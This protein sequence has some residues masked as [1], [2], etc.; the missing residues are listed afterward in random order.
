MFVDK[1]ERKLVLY[2]A[3]LIPETQE[4]DRHLLVLLGKERPRIAYI[5]SA[6]DPTR[7]Y[8]QVQQAYYARYGIDLAPYF[9]LDKT[10]R[11][12]DLS[13][14]LTADAIHLSGGQTFYFLHWLRVR[15]LMEV[16]R[17]YAADG[18]ILIGVSAGAI[19]MTPDIRTTLL[20]GETRPSEKIEPRGLGLVDFA[21]VPHL[22][23]Y[24]TLVDI[25]TYSQQNNIM[26]YGCP[27][28]AGIIV[29]N[30]HVECIGDVI[31]FKNGLATN[32]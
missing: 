2:S 13:A 20:C 22:G 27:D 21:F 23:R 10:Y 6:S 1:V 11:L 12:D 28:N 17:Q 32:P 29:E 3:Q 25:E 19:L 14:L 8:Y 26:V 16:L 5:P 30:N 4:I 31:A 18:G 9:E 24:A 15:N 7:K